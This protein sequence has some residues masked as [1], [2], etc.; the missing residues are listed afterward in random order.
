MKMGFELQDL[1]LAL[2]QGMK[3]IQA[4]YPQRFKKGRNT[5]TVLF[6]GG[7]QSECGK[8]Q[9]RKNEDKIVVRY[10]NPSDAFRGLGRLLGA[11]SAESISSGFEEV[12]Q[13]KTVGVMVDVSRN[14]VV[15]PDVL[16][17]LMC[18]FALMGINTVI[19]YT[20]DTFEVKGEPF[21]GYLRGGYT[22]KELRELDRYAGQL[23]IEMFPCIQT[24]AHLEQILQ[25]PR[26]QDLKDVDGV[27][28][29]EE[30]KT[31][32]WIEK[33]I[34]EASAPFRSKRIHIGMD[35]AHGIGSGNFLKKHGYKKPFDILN[36]HLNQVRDICL[37][38][39]L[40]PMIWSDMYFRLGSKTNHYYDKKTVIPPE[41]VKAIPNGVE[42]VYWDYYH[43]NT[44]FYEDWINRHRALGSEPLMAGGV[45]TWSHFWAA[46]PFSLAATE[47]CMM[48]CKKKKIK[49]VFVTLWGD[50]G[51]E[52]DLFSALPGIQYFADHAYAHQVKKETV[53][54]NFRG[55]CDATFHSWYRASDLDMIPQ[56]A[57]PEES[58]T[59]ISKWLLWDDPFI[60]VAQSQRP[61]TSVAAHY[62][63]LA[64]DLLRNSQL[65]P[66]DRRLLFPAQLAKVLSY[67]SELHSQL[68]R[69]Y[70]RKDRK[71]LRKIQQNVL[72]PCRKEVKKLWKLHRELWL[73]LY[74][75]FGLEVVE[76]RYG[77][78]MTRLESLSDRLDDFI[79]QKIDAIPEFEA[80]RVP[81]LKSPQDFPQNDFPRMTY[82]RV[83]TSSRLR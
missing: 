12:A 13:M 44:A 20:E 24:L 51:M 32:Q 72:T 53:Q 31:Y 62:E 66:G 49:E 52:C 39:D 77:G 73:S 36:H 56:V 34:D 33:M 25:W 81:F 68:S 15:R 26:F 8:F 65:L 19:L 55:S 17:E 27:L 3:E 21:F 4:L 74:K 14:G 9:V 30:K 80:Q 10:Q 54:E 83:A 47:A 48:A 75:P 82:G 46:L 11:S 7:L 16:R 57:S 67:K 76:Q 23:G 18:R 42:L 5:Q 35:E 69:A 22:Q 2:R 6:E 58:T 60:G 63:K 29:A 70:L 1:P 71:E 64:Q 41:V 59:N 50:D 61:R 37:K 28:I 45:W 79:S 78:L 43:T 40:K 38:R